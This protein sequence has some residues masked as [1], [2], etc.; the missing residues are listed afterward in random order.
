MSDTPTPETLSP[1]QELAAAFLSGVDE[2]ATSDA[3]EVAVAPAAAQPA[4]AAVP[5]PPASSWIPREFTFKRNG[6][7][8]THKPSSAEEELE[9]LRKGFDYTAK[10]MS[11]AEEKKQLQGIAKELKEREEARQTSIK[12]FLSNRDT[13]RAYLA[14]LDEEQG[15]APAAQPGTSPSDDDLEP[16]SRAEFAKM[17]AEFEKAAEAKAEAAAE[18]RFKVIV[19]EASGK[20]LE[21]TYRTDFDTTIKSLITKHP[22]LAFIDDV[23]TLIRGAG[24]RA[25][26]TQMALNPDQPVD[27]AL[28][29]AAMVEDAAKRATKLAAKFKEQEK[30]A[31]VER[32]TLTTRGPEPPGGNAPTLT[33]PAKKLSLKDPA[34][35][36]QVIA[37]IQS[38]LK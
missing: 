17:R 5:P 1:E 10:T 24:A 34:L 25:F 23:D 19:E 21:H 12:A 14:K 4:A 8:I 32:S 7:E 22:E 20:H 33:A 37:E 30:V 38:M 29:R 15:G 31:A 6:E 18:K 16:V 2:T 27:P 3:T 26:Q 28:V 35:D 13:I 9:L 36:A 11:L